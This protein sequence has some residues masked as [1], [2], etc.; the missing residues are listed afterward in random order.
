MESDDVVLGQ[1]G[2]NASEVREVTERV[3]EQNL[4][5]FRCN[6][7]ANCIL[8]GGLSNSKY[9]NGQCKGFGQLATTT[10]NATGISTREYQKRGYKRKSFKQELKNSQVDAVVETVDEARFPTVAHF[11]IRP[12]AKA[13]LR[14]PNAPYLRSL[15]GLCGRA[16]HSK[17][18]CD[19]Q[20][21][22]LDPASATA[23]Q[24]DSAAA[25]ARRVVEDSG[26][27]NP[28]AGLR[29]AWPWTLEHKSAG[30]CG[31]CSA[32]TSPS[33]RERHPH[34]LDRWCLH[35]LS[36]AKRRKGSRCEHLPACT[37]TSRAASGGPS[38]EDMDTQGDSLGRARGSGRGQAVSGSTQA[39][40]PSPPVRA[41]AEALP[42]AAL[43][44]VL[45]VQRLASMRAH[46]EKG[47]DLLGTCSPEELMSIY[48]LAEEWVEACI[49]QNS[50]AS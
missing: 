30:S 46:S 20:T 24:L 44:V 45:A 27:L 7:C 13:V 2:E 1:L 23:S 14:D 22:C 16:G 31:E 15:C 47:N 41:F 21:L 42:D 50:R 6:S 5:A 19:M 36:T 4:R 39:P 3:K 25:R 49:Q 43:S 32:C 17:H 40:S 48:Y 9:R 8:P 38:R 11:H 10:E 26:V 28:T 18:L 37:S 29:D 12:G 34:D 33:C 35:C